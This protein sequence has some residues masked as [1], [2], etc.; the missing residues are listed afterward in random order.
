MK[1]MLK[2]IVFWTITGIAIAEAIPIRIIAMIITYIKHESDEQY[3]RRYYRIM[4]W[5]FR[6][7]DC[8]E[9]EFVYSC[10]ICMNRD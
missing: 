1:T 3:Y 6:M 10:G 7:V 8:S 5:Y 2:K 9:D 4:H